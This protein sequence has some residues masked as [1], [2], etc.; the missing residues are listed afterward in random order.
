M[1]YKALYQSK[2]TTPEEAVKCV[3]DGD[4]V[5][6]GWVSNTPKACDHAMAEHLKTLHDVQFRGGILMW[7]PEMFDMENAKD[8]F[9]W[10]SWHMSG[11]ERKMIDRGF[12]FYAPVRYSEVPKYCRETP[13]P[14]R[15]FFAQCAPMDEHGYFNFGPNASHLIDICDRAEEIIIEVNENMPRCLGGYHTGI[16]ISQVTKIV[17]GDNPPMAQLPAGGAP[18][19]DELAMAN[20]VVPLIPDHACLQLGIGGVPNTIGSVI[21][22]SDL[23]DLG[24]H[25]EMYVD[26]FVKL[27]QAGKITGKY[28]ELDPG[29][30][31]YAF[32]AGTQMLYDFIN[33]NPECMCAP[34][35][36]VNNISTISS[37]SNF[38]SIDRKSVV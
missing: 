5:A 3:R 18:T 22:E 9:T 37:L 14:D 26:A 38:I 6:W 29:R 4:W 35:D 20:L 17:E 32:G 34:V 19:E 36:Y 2:L 21:A 13:Y 24:V 1:D 30:Q 12:C 8:H 10:N 15:V 25:T 33:D 11:I 31:V 23:K 27:T 7:K 16:H 28:K